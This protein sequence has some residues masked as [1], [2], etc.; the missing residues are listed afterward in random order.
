MPVTLVVLVTALVVGAVYDMVNRGWG[1]AEWDRAVADWG[2]R[3]ATPASTE[4]L[5]WLTDLG[6]TGLLAIVVVAVGAY[7]VVRRR[8][9]NVVLFLVV[10][11]VGVVAINNGLKWLV[12][13]PRPDVPH[14]VDTSGPSFPSGHSSAAAATWFAV[15]LV[16]SRIGRGRARFVAAVVAVLISVVVAASRVLLGVHWL[17]DV[18][19]G[20]VVGMGLVPARRPR[21]RWTG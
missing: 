3:H 12:D 20:L 7:D 17:T 5:D 19:A 11:V 8:S 1:L 10:V 15:A 13:R 21:V 2:A 16:I 18:V 6:S 4:V 9:L 14:L